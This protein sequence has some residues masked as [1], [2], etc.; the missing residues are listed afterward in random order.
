MKRQAT[1]SENIF[2]NHVS[3]KGLMFIIYKEFSKLNSKK[4]K[5]LIRKQ[6]KDLNRHFTK[7]DIQ[8]A[9]QC[10]KRCSTSLAIREMQIKITMKAQHQN[11]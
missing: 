5:N 7:E 6:T 4:K 11:G 9:N 8:M 2:A 1:S 3:D 10:V